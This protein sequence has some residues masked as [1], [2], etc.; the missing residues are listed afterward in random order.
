MILYNEKSDFKTLNSVIDEHIGSGK[1]FFAET[2]IPEKYTFDK[3]IKIDGK[4]ICEVNK[5]D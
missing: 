5:H 1:T 3:I 2:Y 4:S